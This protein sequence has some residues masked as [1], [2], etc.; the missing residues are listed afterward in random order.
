MHK[1]RVQIK[2]RWDYL[3][4]ANSEAAAAKEAE[5]LREFGIDSFGAKHAEAVYDLGTKVLILEIDPEAD[6]G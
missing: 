1:Y 3:I 4:E 5:A 6:D 2:E